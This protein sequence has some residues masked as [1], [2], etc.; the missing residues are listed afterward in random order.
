VLLFVGLLALQRF[1]TDDRP[2]ATLAAVA[3]GLAALVAASYVLALPFTAHFQ[4]P[5]H[6]IGRVHDATRLRPFLTVFGV[7]LFPAVGAVVA[8]LLA[9]LPDDRDFASLLVTATVFFLI[10]LYLFAAN[11][12]LVVTAALLVSVLA[13][14]LADPSVGDAA[15]PLALAATAVAALFACEVVFLR[16][17]YGEELHR[18]NTVFKLYFQ[19]WLF[20]GI[21]FPALA[22][23]LAEAAKDA[24]PGS[25][26]SVTVAALVGAGVVGSLFYPIGAIGARWH[27]TLSLDG[28]AYLDR[29]H[30]NDAA[31][32]RWLRNLDGSPV[33]LEATGDPYSYFARVSSNTGLSTVLGW[34]NHEGVWRGNDA[35]FAAR[36]RDVDFAYQSEDVGRVLDVLRRYSVRYV[37]VGDL[38]RQK[39]SPEALAKFDVTSESLEPVFRSGGTTVLEVRASTLR[40]I[41]P[42]TGSGVTTQGAE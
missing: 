9:R 15:L 28:T 19:G 1:W 22:R 31:A 26:G 29:E 6:G 30:P 17:P 11:A 34:S 27:G 20:L 2:I 8:A 32:I 12:V 4:A 7:L 25:A 33:V 40:R 38:E 14:V 3:V 10:V 42:S 36:R 39:F 37:F 16:D 24:F 18:M 41:G 35:R 23:A 21:A 13:L 5:F